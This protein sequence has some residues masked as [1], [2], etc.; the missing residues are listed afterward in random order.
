MEDA[1]C[2]TATFEPPCGAHACCYPNPLL[3]TSILCQNLTPSECTALEG[4]STPGLFCVDISCPGPACINRGGDCFAAHPTDPGCDNALCCDKVCDQDPNCCTTGWSASCV[5]R[6][7]TLCS[8]DMCADALPI[9]GTGTFPFDNTTATTDG[10]LHADCINVGDDAQIAK[11]VWYCWTSSC[12]DEVFVRTCGQTELDTKL[13]VYDGCTCPPTDANLLDC[14]DDRCGGGNLQ[15]TAVFH[16]GANRQ[17]LIR[18]GSYPYSPPPGDT[19][20]MTITC[21]PPVQPNCPTVTENCCDANDGSTG[22]GCADE[23]CCETVC[24]CDQYCCDVE[25]D[26]ACASTGLGGSGCGA[27]VLCPVLC[28][29]CPAGT[30]SFVD[31]PT[32]VVDARRPN[33]PQSATPIVGIDMLLVTAPAGADNPSCWSLCETSSTGTANGVIGVTDN[34]DGQFTVQLARS[35]TP[36]ALTKVTY[37]GSN[38]TA[39][40][41]YHPSNVNGVG[42]ANQTDV[43][44][45]VAAF[46]GTFV[47]PWGMYSLDIDRSGMPTPADI[48]EA[49]ALLI[50]EGAYPTWNGTAQPAPNANCP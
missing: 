39:T 14:G 15:S 6:A 48:I 46:D 38:T 29:N 21:G 8:S 28:G 13:A 45:L 22:S 24:G 40:L 3:P 5:T 11:D 18:L 25:W 49:G 34:G 27:D 42:G 1:T 2:A 43:A 47:V 50:G 17:Y 36:G 44:N 10:P 23:A 31:P 33:T 7:R 26:A 37:M 30:V 4:S 41:I 12:T 9:T 16:A 32:G 20:T 35:I 19:G